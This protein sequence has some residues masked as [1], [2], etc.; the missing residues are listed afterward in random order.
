MAAL[1]AASTTD[2]CVH[3]LVMQQVR[4]LDSNPGSPAKHHTHIVQLLLHA[5][6][7]FSSFTH[8][9]VHPCMHTPITT[10]ALL[11]P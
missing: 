3:A 10:T 2:Q 5:C 1:C 7:L 4:E 11:P 8:C 9:I 6:I